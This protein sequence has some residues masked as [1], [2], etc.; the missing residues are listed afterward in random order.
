MYP[1]RKKLPS[2]AGLLLLVGAFALAA[3][4][5]GTGPEA[6]TE[7]EPA[8]EEPPRV[9]ATHSIIGDIVANV[10]GENAEV[11]T[12]V[13]P[14]EDPHVFEPSPSDSAA[15]AESDVLFENGLEFEPWIE[16][17]FQSSGSEA[18][19]IILAEGID[20]IESSHSHEHADEHGDEH[21]HDHEDHGH[22]HSDEHGGDHGHD[23]E[24]HEDHSHE[25]HDH[26]RS[27]ED[28]DHAHEE[29]GHGSSE[30]SHEGEDHAHES[31]DAACHGE[32]E[33]FHCHGEF[34]PHIYF[35]LEHSVTMT[36]NVRDALIEADPDNEAA[37]R[38]NAESYVAEL[39][40]TDAWISARIETIPEENRKL[41]TAHDAF[42]YYAERY[43]LEVPGVAIESFTTEA[44]D[45]SA[46][47]IAA[48]S[49]EIRELGIPA[50]FPETTSNDAVMRRI[51][52]EAGVE[53][54]DPIY[55]DALGE[56]GTEAD[57]Y[58]GMLRHNTTTIVDALG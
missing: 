28:E 7:A 9:V 43:G 8:G 26:G 30:H 38:E 45:P 31:E 58:I 34:D 21:S 33:D 3:A 23:H 24:V 19:R 16:D 44:A 48:L 20:P 53:L 49:D 15:I 2:L 39:R 32:G 57:T 35:D 47:E 36:E 18:R 46:G 51:S 11:E 29:E 50:I 54:A 40:E 42:G 56:S 55:S 10:A 12:L 6:E 5:C 41:V 27:H 17:A 13:G 22:D 14:G 25:E 4:A 52:D 1:T 37:Y